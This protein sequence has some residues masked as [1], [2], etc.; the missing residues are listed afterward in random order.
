MRLSRMVHRIL[1]LAAAGAAA[2]SMTGGVA[3]A[4]TNI[5]PPGNYQTASR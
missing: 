4:A 1:V 5:L 2:L 3:I